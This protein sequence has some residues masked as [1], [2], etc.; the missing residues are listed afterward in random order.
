M[1]SFPWVK[2]LIA[3]LL[4][5]SSALVMAEGSA[6]HVNGLHDN[7]LIQSEAQQ[8]LQK[9]SQTESMNYLG[10]I[11]LNDPEAVANALERAEDFYFKQGKN[12]EKYSPVVL[13]IHGS[14][15]GIFF[16]ENYQRYQSI[17]DLAAKLTA[18]KVVDI[19]V[20]ETSANNLGFDVKTLFPF[21]STVPYGPAEVVR[22][23]EV[24]KY[25]Y[26]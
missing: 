2:L 6:L 9:Q 7:G 19:R 18:F 21:V 23:I 24:E 25:I 12:V 3:Y 1:N 13:V 16:K 11:E 10:R 15:V 17:V 14:E 4:F 22:L 8:K 5:I 20:C 26:F